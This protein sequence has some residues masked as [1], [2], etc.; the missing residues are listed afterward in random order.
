MA[1]KDA[2]VCMAGL[3]Y[4]PNVGKTVTWSIENVICIAFHNENGKTFA[5][6]FHREAQRKKIVH[7]T[8]YYT[9]L[10]STIQ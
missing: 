8:P 7:T 5:L 6:N 9:I 1:R 4:H 3:T 10:D 2:L